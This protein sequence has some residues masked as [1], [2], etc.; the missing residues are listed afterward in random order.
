MKRQ[1]SLKRQT[2]LAWRQMRR[3]KNRL[4]IALAGI[5]FANVLMFMQLGF[6][7]ALYNSSTLLH[8]NLVADLVLVSPQ[9]RN[10]LGMDTISRNRLYQAMSVPGVQS[11]NALYINAIDWKNPQTRRKTPILVI[12]F[13]P[14]KPLLNLSEV[15]Q[16]LD[17][18]KL[19]GRVLF[20]RFSRGDYGKTVAQIEHGETVITELGNQQ[21]RIVGTYNIGPSFGL[22]G[23]LITS[24]VNFLHF[25]PNRS[26]AGISV[27]LISL[28]P[29]AD[30]PSVTAALKDSL[31]SDIQVL[32]RSGFVELE[33]G[34]WRKNTSIGYI[35]TLGTTMGFLVGVIIVYQILYSGVTDHLSEYATL[36]ALGYRDVYL[37]GVV[38]QEAII[39]SVLGYIPGKLIAY[40]LYTLT[41]NATH[42]PMFITLDRAIEI[43]ILTIIMCS[44][45]GIIAMRK[46]SSADPAELF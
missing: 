19:P 42:L 39:L 12:G 25:F 5:A 15:N 35:F 10:L 21:I 33:Q 7:D 3:E 43:L 40:G 29:G 16:K 22:D 2:L 32:T 28:Q 11:A 36:K 14:A 4:W 13:N 46:L 31:P 9:A 8:E 45:S 24:D 30:L 26:T 38:F 37:I 1:L 20:D 41:R 44:I 6:H 18:L 34:Y 27:G 23:S 17:L